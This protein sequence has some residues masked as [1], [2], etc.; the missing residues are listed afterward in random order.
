[1]RPF[2][3]EVDRFTIREAEAELIRQAARSVLDGGSIRSVASTWNEDG[4][5]TTAGN[6]WKSIVVRRML[7]SLRIAG[8]QERRDGQIIEAPWPAIVDEVTHR[9]LVEHLSKPGRANGA[10]PSTRTYLLTG[11]IAKCGLCATSLVARPDNNGKRGY[12]CA[13]G[14]PS[15]GCGKIRINGQLLEDEVATRL[16]ARLIRADARTKIGALLDGVAFDAEKA[17][18]TIQSANSKLAEL[19][20]EYAQGHISAVAMRSANARL[21]DDIGAARSA[22]KTAKDLRSVAV[23]ESENLIDWWEGASLNQQRTL[24]SIL[25]A[26]VEVLPASVKGSKTFDPSRVKVKWR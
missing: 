7:T 17:G 26:K 20:E 21:T 14:T 13:S 8:K 23:L 6:A 2:G 25:V 5:Q 16:I 1:M 9:R 3:Y 12:V 4:I 22:L 10:T 11:G 19:G 18:R 15:G 24:L